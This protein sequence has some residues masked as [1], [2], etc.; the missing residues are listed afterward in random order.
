M[1]ER[2]WLVVEDRTSL[3]K[4]ILYAEVIL[5]T[6]KLHKLYIKLPDTLH[7][8]SPTVTP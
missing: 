4:V 6:E 1:H 8:A 2:H 3:K 7:P 5:D